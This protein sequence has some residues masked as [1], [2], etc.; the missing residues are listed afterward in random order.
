M[1][2]TEHPQ[3]SEGFKMCPLGIQFTTSRRLR[4]FDLFE[5]NLDL[6]EVGRHVSTPTQCTGA[7]V[8]CRKKPGRDEYRVWI[9]F[10][11]IPESARQRIECISKDGR[12][13]C[14]NCENF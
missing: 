5:F 13:L 8:K 2:G 14:H 6:D 7:V 4:P 1:G 10:L 11:D 3:C 12:H 9:K